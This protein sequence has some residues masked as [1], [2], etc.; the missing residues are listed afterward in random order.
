M[1]TGDDPVTPS[2]PPKRDSRSR[3]GC[4]ECRSRKIKCDEQKPECGQCLK[5]GRACRIID[6]VFK[7]HSYSFAVTDVKS[8]LTPRQQR[9]NR[10]ADRPEVPSVQNGGTAHEPENVIGPVNENGM[11][12]QPV[13]S[14]SPDLQG[15]HPRRSFRVNSI[16][17]LD[18]TGVLPKST[19]PLTANQRAAVTSGTTPSFTEPLA[20]LHQSS[21]TNTISHTEDS[22]QDR[23]EIAFFLRH[24]A[25]GPGEWMNVLGGQSYFSRHIVQLAHCSP[26]V[27]YAASALG[28]K[29]LG[30]TRHPETQIRQTNTQRLMMQA[31][32]DT[33]LGFT[34]YGAKYY[35]RAIQLLAKQL[36]STDH[37]SFSLSPNFIYGAEHTPRSE[38]NQPTEGDDRSSYQILA[39]CILCQYEDVNA[40]IRAWSGHLDGVYRLLRPHLPEPTILQGSTIPQPA[41]AVDSVFWFFVVNDMLNGFVTRRKT[42]IDTNDL[43]LWRQMGLPLDGYGNLISELSH[44]N[45]LETVFFKALLRMM[46]QLVNSDL[47]DASQWNT[48]NDMFDR[49]QSAVPPSFYI[50][51]AWPPVERIFSHN[52][53]PFTR[54]IWFSSDICAVTLA[55]YHMSR[56]LLLVSRPMEL[57]MQQ[58]RSN[59]DLLSTYNNLQQELR[60]HAMEIIPIMHA[61]PSDTVQKY[62]LQPL[63][64]AG[65]TLTDDK[66]RKSLLHILRHMGDNLGLF[67]DYRMQDLCEE[68]GMPCDII[69]RKDGYGILT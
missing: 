4:P 1:M 41:R 35:E 69:D 33:R 12:E 38:R 26:L 13:G 10:F 37:S 56:L 49:W 15:S 34:W 14:S 60:K 59:E 21:E 55:F 2:R 6:S 67:P 5:T 63:Y 20:R 22:Y 36:R 11:R 23:C 53:D 31:L 30:Q 64:V 24:F 3:K 19:E 44:E 32:I 7:Q 17:S 25:E 29:Q 57:F 16:I 43:V 68:W 8:T 58:S 48:L 50:P 39:A 27:R 18:E 66:E 47:G 65:R 9:V 54:E 46:C 28:A 45:D 51:V 52:I 62:M 42:R 40:T 61:L